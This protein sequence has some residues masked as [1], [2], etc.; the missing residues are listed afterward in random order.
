MLGK[1]YQMLNKSVETCLSKFGIIE[2]VEIFV[3][4]KCKSLV[5]TDQIDMSHKPIKYS[6]NA[7]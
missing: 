3:A 5:S 7:H 2:M 6:L 4:C 1:L